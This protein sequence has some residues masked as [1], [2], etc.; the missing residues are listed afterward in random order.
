MAKT[1]STVREF[2]SIAFLLLG[3]L[4]GMIIMTFIFGQL[5]PAN[6]G[7]TLADPGFNESI[8]IQNNSLQAIVTYTDQASNQ[9]NIVAIAILLV[10]LI[11]VFLVFWVIFIKQKKGGSSTA[12]GSFG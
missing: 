3:V 2:A 6:A 1:M 5:G 9:F 12:G 10:I 4:F 11:A 8:T 7:L